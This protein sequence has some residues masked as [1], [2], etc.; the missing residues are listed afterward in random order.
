MY[1]N[2]KSNF[3]FLTIECNKERE[4]GFKSKMVLGIN[5]LLSKR[6]QIN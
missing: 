4:Y 2:N 1:A 5:F 3:K 6:Y